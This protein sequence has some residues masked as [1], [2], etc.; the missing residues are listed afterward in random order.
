MAGDEHGEPSVAIQRRTLIEFGDRLGVRTKTAIL[1]SVMRWRD[2]EEPAGPPVVV[3]A[4]GGVVI[5]L[6]RLPAEPL[7]R[8]SG[9][10]RRC[11]RGVLPARWIVGV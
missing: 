11:H 9:R 4:G 3:E 5:D 6:G 7:C 1:G 2:D 8:A 10:V